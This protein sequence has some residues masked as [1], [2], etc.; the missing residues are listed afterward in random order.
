MVALEFMGVPDN[1]VSTAKRF[2]AG[3]MDFKF[4][5]PSEAEQVATCQLMVQNQEYSRDLLERIKADPSGPGFLQNLIRAWE[6][7][8]DLF[9]EPFLLG[10]ATT[11]VAAAHETT[12]HAAANALLLLLQERTRWEALCADPD[13]IP[14]AVEEC[15]RLGPSLTGLQRMC[16]KDA[17]VAGVPIPAGSKVLLSVASGN[18]DEA[19][20]PEAE[21]FDPNRSDARRHLTFGFHAHTCLG[22]P[23][24]RLQM[25]V[26]LEELVRRLPHM[27]LVEG[28]EI[29]YAPSASPHGPRTLLIEWDPAENPLPSDRPA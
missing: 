13:L 16:V 2:A 14:Q 23:L 19:M 22:A 12:S 24:A 7:D 28:Q 21:N 9:E 20:F 1:E 6:E 3:I 10:L 11:T 27:R 5:R 29:T 8:P 25:R 17:V 18:Y 4:G 26:A 15:L